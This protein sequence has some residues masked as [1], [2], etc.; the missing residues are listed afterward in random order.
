LF[1]IDLIKKIKSDKNADRIGPDIPFTHWQ[2]HFREKMVRL[3][4]KKFKHF[5]ASAQFRPGAYAVGCS[6]IEI[7]ERVVIRPGC[8]FFGES[9]Q[10]SPTITIEDNVL[11]GSCVSIYINNH[12][13]DRSDIPLIDQ[14]HYPPKAVVLKK[15]CWVGANCVILPGVTIGENAVVGA[16]SVVT[17]SIPSAVLAAGNPARVIKFIKNTTVGIVPLK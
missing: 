8:R 17:K 16:G 11:I 2:L 12:R 14:G 7:G 1:I 3:C 9:D 6:N 10:L 13:F 5:A 15:G 4:K